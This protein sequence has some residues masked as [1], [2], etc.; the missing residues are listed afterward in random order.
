M[1]GAA[2]LVYLMTAVVLLGCIGAK[3]CALR[4]LVIGAGAH[5]ESWC[6]CLVHAAKDGI[7][8]AQRDVG[9]VVQPFG[10]GATK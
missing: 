3:R 2:F 8:Q 4:D 1:K 10:P 6:V 9:W 5:A 7:K